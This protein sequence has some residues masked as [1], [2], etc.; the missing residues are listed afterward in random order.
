L[1]CRHV[2]TFLSVL[3]SLI[4]A[5]GTAPYVVETVRGHTRPRIVT[6]ATWAVLTAVAGAASLS[7]DQVGG[8]VF[9]LLGTVATTAVVAAG[10]RYGDRS[11]TALDVAC[12]I[13]VL[14][15]LVL[16]LTL[17]NPAVAVWA[18]IVIDF[19]GLLPTLVHA[20]TQP[21]AETASTFACIGA[22]GIITS[23]AVAAGGAFSMPALGYPLY[24]AVSTCTVTAIILLRRRVEPTRPSDGAE[25]GPPRRG[26]PTLRGGTPTPLRP[27]QPR[28]VDRRG[29][30]RR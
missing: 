24:V 11:I 26:V 29:R 5:A 7:A 1:F 22:G 3:G 18:A 19:V 9:A 20:W 2:T 27:L 15:G 13:G 21:R 4:A 28:L 14:V 6:W 17:R 12:L 10:L 30:P 25:V 23:A 8:A 16:W